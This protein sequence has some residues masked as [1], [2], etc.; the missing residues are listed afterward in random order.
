MAAIYLLRD[1]DEPLGD[2]YGDYY[3]W[4]VADHLLFYLWESVNHKF[5]DEI[6]PLASDWESLL[7]L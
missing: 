4:E 2:S 3:V 5:V 1:A 6:L 7:D